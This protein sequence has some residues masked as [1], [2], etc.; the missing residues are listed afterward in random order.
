MIEMDADR[1]EVSD[2]LRPQKPLSHHF[3]WHHLAVKEAVLGPLAA[4]G[5][6]ERSCASHQRRARLQLHGKDSVQM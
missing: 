3:L 5:R 6:E 4:G 1:V 2:A